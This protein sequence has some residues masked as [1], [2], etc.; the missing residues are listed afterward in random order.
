METRTARLAGGFE[1]SPVWVLA[2]NNTGQSSGLILAGHLGPRAVPLGGPM[3]LRPHLFV[4]QTHLAKSL[5]FS[6]SANQV[7]SFWAFGLKPEL[8]L[9]I[10]EVPIHLDFELG[11]HWVP[12]RGLSGFY[13][14]QKFL[15]CE[16]QERFCG[17]VNLF[18][19]Y[20]K[21]SVNYSASKERGASNFLM[22]GGLLFSAQLDRF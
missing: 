17:G 7:H 4:Q 6:S 14:S 21:E 22:G 13:H 1:A 2:E 18:A 5:S 11:S 20:F 15:F 9:N 19:S 10:P 3:S 16:P 12:Q 8:V